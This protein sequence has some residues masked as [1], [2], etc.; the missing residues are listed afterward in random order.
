MSNLTSLKTRLGKAWSLLIERL[1]GSRPSPE[2]VPPGDAG[3]ETLEP[4]S[5][6]VFVINID[7]VMDKITGLRLSQLMGWR[8]IDE[9]I[10]GYKLDVA[11]C[12]GG[13]V[14]YRVIE[15]VDVDDFPLKAD[16]FCYTPRSYLAVVNRQAKAYPQDR[17]DYP[18]ILA[19]HQ[20]DVRVDAGEFDEVWIF[21]GPYFGFLESTMAGKGA[22]FVNGGPVAGSL[23]RRKYVIMGFSYERGVGEMLEDLGHR[24]ESTLARLFHSQEFLSWSYSRNRTT[25]TIGG[26]S[27]NLFERFLCFDQVAPGRANVGTLH[28][29][30]NS[31]RDYEWGRPGPVV[32]CADDWYTYPNLPYPPRMRTVTSR[33]WGGG[34]VRA[35]HRW[36]L[37]HLPRAAGSLGGIRNNWWHYIID[38][39]NVK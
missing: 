21:G 32:S 23:C 3:N 15:R 37:A 12:S 4:L 13:L 8:E 27:L 19:Q 36:W 31:T 2:P 34:D 20:L 26:S 6:R 17:V 38:P 18:L 1:R 35:H 29:A 5:R 11:E 33:D 16:R 30:P 7:P 28:Y 24:A 14:D 10:S 39:N 22:F 9:L 25:R